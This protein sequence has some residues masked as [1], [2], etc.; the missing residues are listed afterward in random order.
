MFIVCYNDHTL[1]VRARHG[2]LVRANRVSRRF[3]TFAHCAQRP[4][5]GRRPEDINTPRLT[6]TTE[7]TL[8]D[9][10]NCSEAA[11]GGTTLPTHPQ[12]MRRTTLQAP[13]VHRPQGGRSA[14]VCWARMLTSRMF[15]EYVNDPVRE[16]H[17]RRTKITHEAAK[18]SPVSDDSESWRVTARIWDVARRL[19]ELRRESLLW[20]PRRLL[21]P[22]SINRPGLGHQ[23]CLRSSSP[24][25]V[26]SRAADSR[27]CV[28]IRTGCDCSARTSRIRTTPG[29]GSASSAS[30]STRHRCFSPGTGS[31]CPARAPHGR[32][33]RREQPLGLQ[34]PAVLERRGGLLHQ[35]LEPSVAIRARVASHISGG[36]P[37]RS[38]STCQRSA[39]SESSSHAIRA[40]ATMGQP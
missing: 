27:L 9:R 23:R 17:D 36:S 35:R 6:A 16:A 4:A 20:D 26:G 38:R 32:A 5:P 19:P 3:T 7:R 1:C 31:R 21:Q 13:A 28:A 14:P 34:Q 8:S 2:S 10:T 40:S 18:I 12:T 25:C 24:T 22:A 11:T 30:V 15:L 33:A 37:T 29:I 39:G